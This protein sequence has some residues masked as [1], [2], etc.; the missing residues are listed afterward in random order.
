MQ[1][2]GFGLGGGGF[3][4]QDDLRTVALALLF[5]RTGCQ[6]RFQLV[7]DVQGRN[8]RGHGKLVD[9]PVLLVAGGKDAAHQL[10][11]EQAGVH[12]AVAGQEPFVSLVDLVFFH[13]N[14][15]PLA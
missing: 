8:T 9:G 15:P 12:V 5:Q 6:Q 4:A 14:R 3:V 7:L 2:D 11:F 1:Q 10:A 13:F